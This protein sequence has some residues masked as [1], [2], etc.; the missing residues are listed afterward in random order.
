MSDILSLF[1][2]EIYTGPCYGEIGKKNSI[3][4]SHRVLPVQKH[5]ISFPVGF[6]MAKAR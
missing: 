1:A 5:E 2:C 4:F 6:Q 3:A